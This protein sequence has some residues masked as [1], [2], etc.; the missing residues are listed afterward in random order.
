MPEDK[1]SASPQAPRKS[2]EAGLEELESVVRQLEGSELPLEK[3]LELFERGVALSDSC[4]KQLLE[5]EARIEILLKKN[6]Q[7]TPEPFQPGN[8]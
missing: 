6:G 3:A 2:F 1:N 7:V 8:A 4:R 5:A